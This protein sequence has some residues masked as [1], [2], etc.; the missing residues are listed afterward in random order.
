MASPSSSFDVLRAYLE[1]RASFGEEELA[2][3]RSRFVP[4]ALRSGE[5]LQRAGEVT[6]Y[7]AFVAKGCLRR[8]L[9]DG[10]GKEHILQFAPETWWTADN[11][12]LTTGEPSQYFIDAIE[13]SELLLISAA[14]HEELV[15]RV[16]GYSAAYR[17]SLQRHT[18]AR[19][20]RIARS[21][22]ASA[23]ERY[24]AFLETYPSIATRVPQWMLA[25][26]LGLTPETLSRIRSQLA[27]KARVTRSG[28]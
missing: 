9:I 20:E 6:K 7:T 19:D 16:P 22:S 13:D 12:S 3:I 2:L 1:A 4:A 17:K 21:L 24:E 27:R 11:A 5:F 15:E 18:A 26:Y 25:S 23:Q 10:T 28:G 8:Y 14:S